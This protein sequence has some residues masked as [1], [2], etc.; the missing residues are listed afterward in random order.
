ML[1]Y[2]FME[3]V[4]ARDEIIFT[5]S[6]YLFPLVAG[7]IHAHWARKRKAEMVFLYYLFFGIGIQGFITGIAQATRPELVASFTQWTSSPFLVELGLANIS[8]GI[9]G[10]LGLWMGKGW[11][12]ATM[13]G[14]GLFLFMTGMRHVVEIA[15][16]GVNA[17]NMGG[18]L[19]V[20]FL[21][22]F[23]LLG[24]VYLNR[25]NVPLTIS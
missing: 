2:K 18:F 25:E 10:C 9:L 23:T 20:D 17:G 16:I 4:L 15:Q 11:K 13:V 8:Y 7:W 14:Y 19:F 24:L 12:L 1:V 21:M 5:F 3:S 22:A 6:Y